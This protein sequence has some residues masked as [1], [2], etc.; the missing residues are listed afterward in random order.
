[1]AK[2][3]KKS[4][5]RQLAVMREDAAEIKQLAQSF[6]ITTDALYISAVSELR[7]IAGKADRLTT[8]R[9]AIT[10]PMDAAKKLVMDLFRE[11]LDQLASARQ[12]IEA[13]ITRFE[14][15]RAA[16]RQAAQLAADQAAERER[17]RLLAQ[18]AK[19]K[20]PET[21]QTLTTR[22]AAVVPAVLVIAPPAVAGIITKR[23]WQFEVT[24]PSLVPREYLSVDEAKIRKV[25]NALQGE[26]KIDGVRVFQG[27]QRAV[28]GT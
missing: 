21:Q 22:A 16:E 9:L 13:E 24:D 20:K 12:I 15:K 4:D 6:A 11:P 17:Q 10:R 27:T 5:E 25:V 26:T 28:S 8:L 18:A 7:A 1:M 14:N 3:L 19:A 2:A 23:P